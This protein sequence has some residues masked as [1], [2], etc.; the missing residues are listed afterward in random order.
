MRRGAPLR[1]QACFREHDSAGADCA[2]APRA[3]ARFTQERNYSV[4]ERRTQRINNPADDP[5]LYV[6]VPVQ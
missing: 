2:Y 4:S 5:R 6:N 1:Q 3:D